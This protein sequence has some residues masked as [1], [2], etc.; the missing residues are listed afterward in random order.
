MSFP[1][2]GAPAPAAI[3]GQNF[4]SVKTDSP[5][6][7]AHNN[8][9]FSAPV[10]DEAP[11]PQTAPVVQESS[12]PATANG[13]RLSPDVIT[14][15]QKSGETERLDVNIEQDQQ[16]EA[17]V[18]LGGTRGELS[19]SNLVKGDANQAEVAQAESGEQ[20]GQQTAAS[21]SPATGG[22]SE[23]ARNPLNLQ[24]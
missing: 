24:I 18:A 8:Q 4:A 15:L 17:A 21:V 19:E 1:I 13:V 7:Q 10:T 14:A 12:D 23:T 2:G 20:I 6:N 16:A 5:N 22:D 11:A 3:S 9:G